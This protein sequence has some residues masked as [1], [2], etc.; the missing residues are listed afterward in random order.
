[1][2]FARLAGQTLRSSLAA[3]AALGLATVASAITLNFTGQENGEIDRTYGDRVTRT[4]QDS[5]RSVRST[6]SRCGTRTA[7]SSMPR[8]T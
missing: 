5:T 4:P 7:R 6:R 8:R 3:L 2:T 1:M